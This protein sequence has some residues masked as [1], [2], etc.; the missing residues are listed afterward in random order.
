[1]RALVREHP[2]DGGSH[3]L[4]AD[5][6]LVRNP[7]DPD[8]VI[9]AFAARTLMPDDPYAWRRWATIQTDRQRQLEALKSFL[10]YF[11]IGGAAA[12]HDAEAHHWASAL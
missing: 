2:Y 3:A 8:A 12:E 10:R 9:E 7:R 5:L 6:L 11:R 1:M 4:L